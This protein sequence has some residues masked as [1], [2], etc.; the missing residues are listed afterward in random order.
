MAQ[1]W[2]DLSVEEI[3]TVA[4][5]DTTVNDWIIVGARP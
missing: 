2:S 4:T 1:F 5:P 3:E